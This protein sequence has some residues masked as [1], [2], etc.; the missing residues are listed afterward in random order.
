VVAF[1]KKGLNVER[2]RF[3]NKTPNLV[4]AEWFSGHR[5]RLRN[6]RPGFESRHDIGLLRENI[7]M[8]M[9]TIDL[10]WIARV[11]VRRD[12]YGLDEYVFDWIGWI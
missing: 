5:I 11:Y 8:L 10:I 1:K 9:C 4:L 6:I 2:G 7:V 3:L 12:E